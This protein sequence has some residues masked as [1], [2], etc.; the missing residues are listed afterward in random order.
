MNVARLVSASALALLLL[1]ST[2]A[3]A[4]QHATVEDCVTTYVAKGK[5]ADVSLT[6]C[7]RLVDS[8][9]TEDFDRLFLPK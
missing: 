9:T 5:P 4:A 3:C 1:V 6:V 8:Q 2:S 7:E